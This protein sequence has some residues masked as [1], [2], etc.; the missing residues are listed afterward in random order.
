MALSSA[1]FGA[2]EK[3]PLTYG[4]AQYDVS[5]HHQEMRKVC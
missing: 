1:F 3:V 4:Q 2:P 5:L